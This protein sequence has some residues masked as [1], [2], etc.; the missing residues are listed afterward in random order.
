MKFQ[1]SEDQQGIA[2]GL[3]QMLKGLVTDESLKALAK[4]GAWFHERA[5]QT[6]AEAEMLGLAIPEAHGGAGFGMLELCLLLE[7]VGRTVAPIPA[8]ETLVSTALP[9]AQF[10]TD[11]QRAR[12]LPGIAKGELMLTAALVDGGTRDPRSPAATAVRDGA[13]FK[14]TGTF[15]NVAYVAQAARVLLAAKTDVGVLVCLVDPKA[16]GVAV[17]TQRGTNT[18]P[19]SRLTLEGVSVAADDVLGTEQTGASVLDFAIQRTLVGMA[20]LQYGVAR[21]ALIMTARYASE[22]KQFGMPIGMFQAVKQ[23]LAD[24]YIDVGCME[25][26]MLQAAFKLDAER[27]AAADILTAKF[28]AA[29]GGQRVLFAAQHVHGGMG[30]D[31]DYPLFRYFLTGKHLEFTL[32]GANET[33]ER[34]G[35]LLAAS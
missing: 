3:K 6:L 15:T 27:D 31:R 1:L 33:V 30:F 16:A 5:W 23:R 21:E 8:L 18:Q 32:G 34:L 11:A 26:T 35:A 2:D 29:E 22:R 13:G 7:Q 19:L 28:W 25:V 17:D 14:V 20:A 4:E 9:I 12:F 24:A 10:G